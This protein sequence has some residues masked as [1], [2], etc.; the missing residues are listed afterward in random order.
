VRRKHPLAADRTQLAVHRKDLLQT[1]GA[2]RK[3]GNVD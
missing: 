2:H 3:P 1:F